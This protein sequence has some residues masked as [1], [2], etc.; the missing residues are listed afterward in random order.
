MTKSRGLH[1][2]LI[3]VMGDAVVVCDAEGLI[4]VWNP[5]AERMF[6]F[7]SAEAC[8]QSLDI[9]I[10]ERLRERHWEGY[11]KTM[12]TGVTRYGSDVLQVPAIDKH[13]KSM[14]IAFTVALTHDDQ[15]HVS[16]IVSVI[17][18]ETERFARDRLQR[19]KLAELEEAL[20][21]ATTKA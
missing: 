10:P 6:G 4:T 9:I 7:T 15:G 19:K 2:E 17:R 1:E 16:S 12:E 13:G 18:E 3:E 8:G 14:S 20:K 5:A 11:R 21:A